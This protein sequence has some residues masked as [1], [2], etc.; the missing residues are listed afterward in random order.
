MNTLQHLS[1][2]SGALRE[3]EPDSKQT[4][5]LAREA[6]RMTVQQIQP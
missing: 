5:S 4:Q 3:G 1:S 6:D 2:K